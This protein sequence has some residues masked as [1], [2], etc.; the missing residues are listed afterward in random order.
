ML[1]ENFQ[2]APMGSQFEMSSYIKAIQ[3]GACW[4]CNPLIPLLETAGS[5]AVY[6]SSEEILGRYI[7]QGTESLW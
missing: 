5:P 6:V 7:R 1:R 3:R 4:I 2:G